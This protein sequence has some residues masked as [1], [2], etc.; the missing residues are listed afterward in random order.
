MIGVIIARQRKNFGNP[1]LFSSIHSLASRYY[2][3]HIMLVFVRIIGHWINS[4]I[5]RLFLTC[6]DVKYL[7]SDLVTSWFSFSLEISKTDIVNGIRFNGI[8]FR[9]IVLPLLDHIACRARLIEL[10]TLSPLLCTIPSN[11]LCRNKVHLANLPTNGRRLE[12]SLTKFRVMMTPDSDACNLTKRDINRPD[13]DSMAPLDGAV[14]ILLSHL[15][16]IALLVDAV[17]DFTT[18]SVCQ[19]LL[20]TE[21]LAKEKGE[22][23]K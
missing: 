14:V 21:I 10:R 9:E 7:M 13:G 6:L 3:A 15:S 2:L 5:S 12:N 4:I 1:F 23:A 8:N 22:K 18:A 16:S 11:T 19:E 17:D 20:T